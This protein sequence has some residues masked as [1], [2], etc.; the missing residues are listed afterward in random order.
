MNFV[1]ILLDK[2]KIVI[3]AQV[4]MTFSSVSILLRD[5]ENMEVLRSLTKHVNYYSKVLEEQDELFEKF[6]DHIR[7]KFVRR[8]AFE[9][10]EVNFESHKKA[11]HQGNFDPSSTMKDYMDL[12]NYHAK[13]QELEL[14][15]RLLL[16][17]KLE[18]MSADIQTQDAAGKC[19]LAIDRIELLDMLGI[20]KECK[21]VMQIDDPTKIFISANGSRRKKDSKEVMMDL[22]CCFL[23]NIEIAQRFAD[24]GTG[25]RFGSR[26]SVRYERFEHQFHTNEA[27][28]GASM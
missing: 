3:K 4:A 20:N 23:K 18:E 28:F 14:S 17:L 26:D 11:L 13:P 12:L 9:E 10:E 24:R 8:L 25:S 22:P 16:C 6:V 5:N 1:F 2:D 21:I 7:N 19:N 15:S 27:F